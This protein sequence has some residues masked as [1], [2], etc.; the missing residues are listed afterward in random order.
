MSQIKR[1]DPLVTEAIEIL[2]I[3]L[4]RCNYDISVAWNTLSSVYTDFINDELAKCMT[5]PRYYLENY[6]VI[7]SEH[8]GFKTLY[9]F[10]DSQE[11]FFTEVITLILAGKPVKVLVLKARQLGM[12]ELAEGIIFWRTIFNETITTLIVAQDV[13]QADYLFTKS[14]RAY[15]NLPWWLQPEKRYGS[16]GRYL[17]LD[18]NSPER[19]GLGS[20]IIV[21]AAN[22]TAGAAIG[23]CCAGDS[24]IWSTSGPIAI[25]T[26]FERFADKESIQTDADGGEW[27][28]LSNP[29]EVISFDGN[30]QVVRTVT[31]IYRQ[32]Y[33]GT[34]EMVRVGG[35]PTIGKTPAHR[36]LSGEEWKNNLSEGDWVTRFKSID[37]RH[38]NNVFSPDEAELLAWKLSEGHDS[39][40]SFYITQSDPAMR[41]RIENVAKRVHQWD[42]LYNRDDKKG[43]C[44]YVYLRSKAYKEVMIGKGHEWNLISGNKAIPENLFGSS[45]ESIRRFLQ[46][47]SEAEGCCSH[48]IEISTKSRDMAEGL[49]YLF[50]MFGIWIRFSEN[51][52]CATNT[53]NKTKRPYWR[54]MICGANLAKFKNEIGFISDRKN[55]ILNRVAAKSTGSQNVER[56]PF[57][58][59]LLRQACRDANIRMKYVLG[60]TRY[61]SS[62]LMGPAYAK[63][64]VGRLRQVSVSV[65]RNN[66]GG[67]CHYY[68]NA[69]MDVLAEYA[70]EAE[71]IVALPTAHDQVVS[72]E[73][74]QHDGYVY[75]L[76][77][78]DTHNYCISGIISH[79]T[80]R[81]AH[82]SELSAWGNAKVLT[83]QIF[84]T[85]NA[86]DTISILES[87]ARGRKG[88]WYDF[89]NEAESKWGTDP[90]WQWK[91][92]FIEWFRCPTKYFLPIKNKT[93][94]RLSP[95]EMTFREKVIKEKQFF[96]P[97][98]MFN[99]K[100]M[101][102]NEFSGIAGDEFGFMQEYPSNP[103]ESF[104]SS[105]ICAFPKKKLHQLMQTGAAPPKWFGELAYTHGAPQEIKFSSLLSAGK[106]TQVFDDNGNF[107][108]GP[109]GQRIPVPSAEIW[110]GR[111]RVWEQPEKGESYYL[112]ADV[113]YGIE[114]R[115]D[116]S[117]AQII[118]IGR[119]SAPDVQVAE[120]RGWI[121]PTPFGHIIVGLA[122]HY[123]NCEVAIETNEVGTKTYVEVFRILQY[124]NMYRWK[125]YD[126]IKNFYTD[127]M[128]WVTTGKN[129]PLLITN[130]TER[131]VENTVRI[132]SYDLLNEMLD[133]GSEEEGDK[134]EAQTG[135]DD[136]PMAFMIA[137]WCAHDSDYG[138]QAAMSKPSGMGVDKYFVIDQFGRIVEQCDS[139]GQAQGALVWVDEKGNRRVRA[140]WSI[141]KRA[142]KENFHNS[143]YSPVFDRSGPRQRLHQVFGVP[144]E[145]IGIEPIVEPSAAEVDT[146]WRSF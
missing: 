84:P 20:E 128:G 36:F 104:Q 53:V 98:E 27:Y 125:H 88:F 114:G 126:K 55:E 121:N 105:G 62:R 137:L 8:E 65:P 17:I 138:K 32:K 54:G 26:A 141:A 47:Y 28:K 144:T 15:E 93:E 102:V 59:M 76:E 70:T 90:S 133:F 21:A 52:K 63:C 129:R 2:D 120:W 79:N 60:S 73:E 123:N 24:R 117:C 51:W 108:P 81:C 87:T 80:I 67:V 83:E 96:I 113:A 37:H 44:G 58:T 78:E 48:V 101:K 5:S 41:D 30:S 145:Q 100:R 130:L 116:F 89:W 95:D 56:D 66:G 131:L 122:K 25:Q 72:V 91:P 146:D 92:I 71:R 94:F 9:P 7:K 34:L 31:R 1:R 134:M 115:G 77:V 127:F 13:E 19:K 142:V 4:R 43:K 57:I 50:A 111:L 99:W 29:M 140:G 103:K 110:G 18:A 6:H 107:I 97:D 106:L 132:Y 135:K 14:M 61:A 45:L 82:L 85:M 10:W 12:S 112:G 23:K 40:N 39:K 124:Q 33:T 143:E 86:P 69:K 38:T 68:T 11:I 75:D 109:D 74:K 16:K 139:Q 118:R 35:C 42:S 46:V 22:K 49:R 64:A 136:R 119:G 3:H